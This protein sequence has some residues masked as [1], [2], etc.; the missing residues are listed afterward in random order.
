MIKI[1]SVCVFVIAFW[2]LGFA[3]KDTTPTKK[4]WT[5]GSP[6]FEKGQKGAVDEVSVKDPSIVYYENKWHLFYTARSNNEYTT[7]Y[8]SAAKL[9]DFNDAARFELKQIRG[10]TRY[11]CA[12]QVFYFEPHKKWYLIYQ[13]KDANYQPVFSTNPEIS[14]PKLWAVPRKLIEKDS[15]EKWIDFWVMADEDQV[16]FFYTEGHN[17]VMMR[18][19]KMED[20]PNNWS[21]SKKMF[22]DVHEAVHIYKVTGKNEFH[23]IYE[24]NN[25]G[26]RSFGLAKANHLEGPWERVTDEY[27]SGN[28]LIFGDD[29]KQWTEMVSHGEVIR[30]GYDQKLE[31][32]PNNCRWIIQGIM[33]NELNDDYPSLPWKLGIIQLIE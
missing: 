21:A 23:M 3:Q 7:A 20:F 26:E 18:S 27:A 14:E 24:L 16:Y 32:D 29:S 5:V 6:I 12:P 19:T 28:Q 11:G 31:Y 33:K 4:Q 2:N 22:D 1:V 13:N 25:Q 30:A 10:K 17:G 15:K 9:E 8:A